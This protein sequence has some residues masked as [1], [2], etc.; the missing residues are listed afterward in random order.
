MQA[1]TCPECGGELECRPHV[2]T[3][4]WA[5][6][7]DHG[8]ALQGCA[9]GH[10]HLNDQERARLA[11]RAAHALL[12]DGS[13]DGTKHLGDLIRMARR[14]LQLGQGDLSVLLDCEAE[15][16]SRWEKNRRPMPRT[17]QLALA[18]RLAQVED[19]AA[20]ADLVRGVRERSLVRAMRRGAGQSP[21]LELQL[22]A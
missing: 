5:R 12:V 6:V 7:V 4:G 16:L 17:F 14:G 9:Q 2:T 21:A 8:L 1:S 15:T 10:F 18:A 20:V 11:R 19:G 13:L 22:S 3:L